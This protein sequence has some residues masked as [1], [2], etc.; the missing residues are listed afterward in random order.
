[1]LRAPSLGHVGRSSL[2]YFLALFDFTEQCISSVLS[3]K[4]SRTVGF[5]YFFW[6]FQWCTN[7]ATLCPTARGELSTLTVQGI[8]S[9][10]TLMT[11]GIWIGF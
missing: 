4:I 10:V 8:L 5:V 9:L 11:F 6:E 3:D 2:Q 1:M 7:S